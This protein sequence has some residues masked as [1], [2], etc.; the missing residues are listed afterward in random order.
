MKPKITVLYPTSAYFPSQVGGPANSI[1]WMCS[2]LRQS[3]QINTI[4]L[5]TNAG[6]N[7]IDNIQLNNWYKN[8]NNSFMFIKSKG[9]F[10]LKLIFRSL[11]IMPKIDI[12]HLNSFFYPPSL[13]LAILN[14]LFFHKKLVLSIRGELYPF[15]LKSFRPKLKKLFIKVWKFILPKTI[16]HCTVAKEEHYVKSVLGEKTNTIL[17][18][19][20]ILR[21]KTSYKF[22]DQEVKYFLFL[23]RIH[24]IKGLENMIEALS[25]SNSFRKSSVIVKVA[26]K[27][28]EQYFNE[29]ITL[30][31]QKNLEEKIQ[32]IGHVEGESKEELL[33][34]AYFL[35][36]PSYT[37]NFGNVVVESLMH[38]TPAI[39]STGTPWEVLERKN[40]GFW[41]NNQ[42]EDLSYTI[43]KALKL[44]KENY[45]SYRDN[46]KKLA[47]SEFDVENNYQKWEGFYKNIMGL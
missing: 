37:E 11:R 24:K 36:L 2:G 23:G 20:Y 44:T 7:R 13:I 14:A 38:G 17:I 25:Q 8:G 45:L 12:L 19:N 28:E 10:P 3:S 43:D 1:Y 35:I 34:N 15:A 47:F 18:P 5:A 22:N 30:T 31:K 41:T 33:A 6:I 26:G 46:A 39:T 29:L 27:G 9:L 4:V 42:A 40:C 21:P 16:V 32:F